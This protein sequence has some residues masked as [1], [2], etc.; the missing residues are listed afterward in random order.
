MSGVPSVDAAST[1][2]T[3]SG[4][5]CP[6]SESRRSEMC[7]ASFRTVTTTLA[8]GCSGRSVGGVAR[9]F[10]AGGGTLAGGPFPFLKVTSSAPAE[11]FVAQV[12]QHFRGVDAAPHESDVLLPDAAEE[13]QRGDVDEPARR[14]EEEQVVRP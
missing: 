4:G 10:S 8:N 12:A 7:R 2:T 9:T 3:S 5:S 1:M 11:E 6:T 13:P 14:R